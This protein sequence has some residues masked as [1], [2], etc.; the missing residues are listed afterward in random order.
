M[1]NFHEQG[2]KRGTFVARVNATDADT[3][4]NGRVTYEILEGG[5]NLFVINS[6]SGV[7]TVNGELD[8]ES[9]YEYKV[10]ERFNLRASLTL[11]HCASCYVLLSEC[12][13]PKDFLKWI[14]KRLMSGKF[15][16]WNFVMKIR[17]FH[18]QST[19]EIRES[20]NKCTSLSRGG[21]RVQQQMHESLTWR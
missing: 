13:H 15:V 11:S 12:L 5:D 9:K 10:C 6:S 1:G 21:K 8:K 4:E 18:F 14:F 3:L 20:N 19:T 17:T 7:I 2:A 16:Q